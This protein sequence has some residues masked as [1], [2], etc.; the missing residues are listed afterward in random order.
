VKVGEGQM[1][2][3]TFLRARRSDYS[4]LAPRPLVTVMLQFGKE[5]TVTP[6][7]TVLIFHQ[8]GP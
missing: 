2:L 6:W 7:F 5:N 1:G 8:V 3:L 4:G